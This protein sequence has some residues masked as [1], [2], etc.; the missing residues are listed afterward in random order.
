MHGKVLGAGLGS[1]HPEGLSLELQGFPKEQLRGSWTEE[2]APQE[3][4]EVVVA[5]PFAPSKARSP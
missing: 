3:A 4:S 5:M 2:E 1:C